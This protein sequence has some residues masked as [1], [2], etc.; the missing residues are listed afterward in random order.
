MTIITNHLLVNTYSFWSLGNKEQQE[1]E[2]Q[3]CCNTVND[4]EDWQFFKFAGNWYELSE[5]I[6]HKDKE[7]P[8]GWDG[9]IE[10]RDGGELYIKTPEAGF[11]DYFSQI[12]LGVKW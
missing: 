10:M 4:F 8:K 1:I 7:M 3:F 6:P 5:G 9:F 11:D 2:D 12:I